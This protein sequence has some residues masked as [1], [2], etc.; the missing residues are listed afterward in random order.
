M[1]EQRAIVVGVDTS[2]RTDAWLEWAVRE[3]RA[4]QAPLRLV[5]GYDFVV[6]F[7][8]LSV[9]LDLRK[10]DLDHAKRIAERALNE[11]EIQAAELD[12]G[13]EVSVEAIDGEAVPTLLAESLQAQT[14]V[15]GSRRLGAA[16]S[17]VLG[18]VSTA[19]AARAACPAV[20]VR[21]AVA[22][23]EAQPVVVGV[24]GTRGSETVLEYAFGYASAHGVP[25]HAVLCWQPN[26][27]APLVTMP[28]GEANDGVHAWLSEALAG[29]REKFPDV[30]VTSAVVENHP[31]A[32]LTQAAAG[33]QLLVVGSIGRHAL[34]GTLLGSVSQGVLHHAQCPVAVVPVNA[35]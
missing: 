32:G 19:V 26:L 31:T 20:V 35:D 30:A 10:L 4:R 2:G 15:L 24:D 34:A 22:A 29:W 7:G 9:Y 17:I 33:A 13:V 18:S 21:G 23:D 25:L 14:V 8:N 1:S 27:L 12:P 28:A 16:G 5:C 3:A 11:A 6:P